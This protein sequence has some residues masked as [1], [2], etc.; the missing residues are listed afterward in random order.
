MHPHVSIAVASGL[1]GK[2]RQ[3][4]YQMEKRQTR[5]CVDEEMVLVY[6]KAVRA[7]QPRIGTRKLHSMLQQVFESNA[8]KLGR[9]KLFALLSK[10][11]LLVRRRRRRRKTTDSNHAFRKYH[12]LIEEYVPTGPEQ[13]WVSDITY[14]SV[15]SSFVYLSLV[16]DLYSKQIMGYHIAP[17]LEAFGPLKALNMAL[18][19]R[20]YPN[21]R[22]IHHS[23]RGIQY[24]CNEYTRLLQRHHI[25]ISMSSKGSPEENAV[26]ER[27]N[28]VLKS[29]FYLDRNFDSLA[30]LRRVVTQTI[31]IY[32]TRR[33]HA[34]CDY[35]TPQQA[36][37]RTGEL[38]K[39]WRP[40]KPKNKPDS[41]TPIPQEAKQVLAQLKKRARNEATV[42]TTL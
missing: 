9:D 41:D 40:Y 5:A 2:S 13:V 8:T 38:K 14:L 18:K 34:S 10:N 36:H 20:R 37:A 24:C 26:A 22:L 16:T 35:L 15:G 19:N 1:F 42:P 39:R 11:G 27:V 7:E 31:N 29:E 17:T 23:D 6:V 3:A 28:G 30:Q 32:N 33:P 12:N 25:L 21:S 4:F